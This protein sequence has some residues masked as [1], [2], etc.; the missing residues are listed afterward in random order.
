MG[1]RRQPYPPRPAVHW[2]IC[3]TC[4]GVTQRAA[5]AAG[6]HAAC[7]YEYQREEGGLPPAYPQR[8][9]GR[10][11][12][13]EEIAGIFELAVRVLIKGEQIGRS[14]HEGGRGLAAQFGLTDRALHYRLYW[15]L[16]HLPTDGRGGKRL[17]FWSRAL[18]WAKS[19]RALRAWARD[20][21]WPWSRVLRALSRLS[22]N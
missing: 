5:R 15:L 18:R 6:T 7:L 19:Y 14:G 20:N 1:E 22:P 13:P 11:Y 8:G 9:R 21:G 17:A 2:G 4:G 10:Q 16:D 12:T 3:L